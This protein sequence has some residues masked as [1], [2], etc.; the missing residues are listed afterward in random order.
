[1]ANFG[2]PVTKPDSGIIGSTDGW[3]LIDFSSSIELQDV[4]TSEE[5][6]QQQARRASSLTRE[7]IWCGLGA[8]GP[9]GNFAPQEGLVAKTPEIGLSDGTTRTLAGDDWLIVSHILTTGERGGSKL[10]ETQSLRRYSKW[11]NIETEDYSQS[12]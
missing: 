3:Y 6:T 2:D 10:I 7:R 8:T 1:M 4:G 11:F 5:D 9:T 12:S